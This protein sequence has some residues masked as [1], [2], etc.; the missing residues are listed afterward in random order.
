MGRIATRQSNLEKTLI[1]LWRYKISVRFSVIIPTYNGAKNLPPLLDA[2]TRQTFTDF[3]VIVVDD[4]S[5]DNTITLLERYPFKV[6]SSP[7]NQGPAHC[8]NLGAKHASGEI[9]VFTD[10]D[11]FVGPHW[12]QQ[13]HEE[14]STGKPTTAIMGKLILDSST[15][16]G[17]AISA[18]G[19]PAGG[20]IGFEKIWRVDAH[21]YTTSLSTCNCAIDK[22]AFE[23][24]GGFDTSFPY[25][26]GED[27]YLAY[28]L[29]KS[30]KKIRYCPNVVAYHGARD[31]FI[32]FLQWQFK[33]GISSWI[34]SSK[35]TD[36]TSF[37]SLRA[38]STRNV[39]RYNLFQA[40]LPLVLFLLGTS[41]F[42]QI[43]GYYVGKRQYNPPASLPSPLMDGER[44]RKIISDALHR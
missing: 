25:A 19:F 17:N 3:E 12:L 14:F 38:W 43:M 42:V 29:I 34:F 10:S 28:C 6:I 22:K 23:D 2:L 39:L 11:C 16:L 4:S 8:R 37:V 18:L 32:G 5:K 13:I 24:T 7:I 15:P 41:F 40:R 21:G 9:L 1:T 36:K 30:R 35:I 33:R 31:S 20:S 26:G 27:S 44:E